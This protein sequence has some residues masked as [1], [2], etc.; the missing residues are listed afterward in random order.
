M[1]CSSDWSYSVTDK[2]QSICVPNSGIGGSCASD[3]SCD[4]GY[5]F[6]G[7]CHQTRLQEGAT[8]VTSDNCK[9][10]LICNGVCS[11]WIPSEHYCDYAAQNCDSASVC[12]LINRECVSK[13]S[14]AENEISKDG[15]SAEVPSLEI[16]E[17]LAH[18]QKLVLDD[19]DVVID[20]QYVCT[21]PP[22]LEGLDLDGKKICDEDDDCTYSYDGK[23][24]LKVSD[25]DEDWYDSNE[26]GLEWLT[27]HGTMTKSDLGCY[28]PT[29]SED[30]NQYCMLGGGETLFNIPLQEVFY[31]NY[32]FFLAQS[33]SRSNP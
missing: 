8:C 4:E 11:Y 14:Y 32:H 17:R 7:F 5:C 1:R 20:M 3:L 21:T 9:A 12:D 30:S 22:A 29:Y 19:D 18:F 33:V 6:G 10:G 27:Y 26:S 28:C 25:L 16:C 31:I 2:T 15:M 13:M 24:G 23:S